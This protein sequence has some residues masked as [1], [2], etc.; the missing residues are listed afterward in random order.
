MF[1]ISAGAAAMLGVGGGMLL[2]SMGNNGPDMSGQVQV[3]K[4]QSALSKEELDWY[5]Q[6]Y[7][8][9]APQ[10]SDAEKRAGLI[11]DAELAAMQSA[12]KSS[13]DYDK[14][15]QEVFRPL[16]RGIVSDAENYDTLD[17]RD[18]AAGQAIADV[19]QAAAGQRAATERN[20]TRMGM[21]PS[22]GAYGAMERA[23]DAS[24]TLSEAGAANRARDQVRTVGQ[25]M[26]MDAASLGRGLPSA[27]ATQAS[28][29]LNAGQGSVAAGMQPIA[30][31]TAGANIMQQGFSGAANALA[32]AGNTYGSANSIL[33]KL[34]DNSGLY[35]GL[36]SAVGSYFAASD[37]AAKR[38]IDDF[39][40][41]SALEA[42]EKTPV[43]KWQYKEG[44]GDGG[45]H[46]GPM[47]QDVEKNMGSKAAP[48]GKVI[49]LV[50]MNGVTM[51]AVQ[52]L[53]KKVSRIA[54]AAGVPA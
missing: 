17:R 49:D 21:N 1:G 18:K 38:G 25:A 30:A 10:R 51:A 27:Q 45:K 40:E 42:V 37:I 34:S 5:K 19:T 22:D 12:T 29:A 35:Q 13:Q 36:G 4:D 54:A 20:F 6:I 7:A 41:D 32:G 11:S 16:E 53:A 28:L 46:V 33:Q 50:T 52:S 44:E 23:A 15:N 9:S 26:K 39:D 43:K 2:S 48:G 8:D 24:T 31:T 3:A 47:A 14:Y